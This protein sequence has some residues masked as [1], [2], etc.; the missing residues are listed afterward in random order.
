MDGF[1]HEGNMADVSTLGAAGR[2]R[3]HEPRLRLVPALTL[4]SHAMAH[5]VGERLVLHPL[6]LGREV[7]V[8]RNLP[9]F[10]RPGA[11]LGQPLA[12][13]FLSRKPLVFSPAPQEGL[14]LDP[15]EGSKVVLGGLPL[16]GPWEFTRQEVAEGIALELAGRVVLVLHLAEVPSEAG[17]SLGMVGGGMGIQRVRRHIEQVADLNVPVLVRGETGSGKELIARAIHQRST[18]RDKA[19]V[20]VNLGAIPRELAAAELFGAHK[21]AYTG[22]TR[23]R[24]GF[25]RAAHG[26]TLFL[27][28]V[29]EAPPEVQVMLLRVLET[30]DIYPVGGHTPVAT[31]VRLIAATDAQL[32]ER[33]QDGRF[34]AP[35]LHRLSG[36]DLRV[37]PLRERREDIGL[38]FHHFAREVLEELGEAW[39]LTPEDT[40]AEPWLP[41]PL[42]ARLVRYAWPG[43]IRQLRNLSRQ[44]I[45]GSRGQPRLRLDPR[46]EGELDAAKDARPGR[47]AAAATPAPEGKGGSR[48]KASEVTEPELLAALRECAWDLKATADR[49]GIPRSSIYDL[50][51][52]SPNLRTA[53]DLSVEELTRCHQE[54]GGDLEAMA[55]RL[56][57]SKR[58]LGRRIKELG[59]VPGNT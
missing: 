2:E 10:Q 28:E 22:S 50:I 8:S 55:Q 19:F 46:L 57:V 14:R 7:A 21:G 41:A 5:R 33:I 58:A 9:D 53:G 26:G 11:P 1:S 47:P 27:D 35:L 18:R 45:I 48:R 16:Q 40:S 54:C 56:E 52:K 37:P 3:V 38:L 20:S 42:A 59:L 29:G 36:Y 31:D 25:F 23:D 44:L 17:D 15:G 30:G 49:L 4:V 12:D 34:K 32:E 43:N 13:P 51:D 39:R 24:E 6:V